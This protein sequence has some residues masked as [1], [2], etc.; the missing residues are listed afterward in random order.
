MFEYE[1]YLTKRKL[2]NGRWD[3][4]LKKNLVELSVAD[5]YEDAKY[6]WIV[7]GNVWYIPTHDDPL[8][9]L[10]DVHH[11]HP[12]KCLCTHKIV[13][14]FEIENTENGNKDIVG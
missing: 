11:T 2:G 5:N 6:E 7:T 12:H 9:V 1:D 14:H 13:W 10:P 3:K 8:T 4:V